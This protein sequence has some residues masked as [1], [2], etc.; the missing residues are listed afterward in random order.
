MSQ[1]TAFFNDWAYYNVG[2]TNCQNSILLWVISE[3]R[4]SEREAASEERNGEHH[5]V[6]EARGVQGQESA[7]CL[8]RADMQ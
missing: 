2:E 1:K 6:R 4:D 5:G 3:K 7:D 8:G